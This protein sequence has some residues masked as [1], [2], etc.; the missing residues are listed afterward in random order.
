MRLPSS[1]VTNHSIFRLKIHSAVSSQATTAI[2]IGLD[3]IVTLWIIQKR[4]VFRIL[5]TKFD[6]FIIE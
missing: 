1:F 2:F 6:I 3:E 5:V 4:Q